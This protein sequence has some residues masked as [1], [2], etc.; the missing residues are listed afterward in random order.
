[1]HTARWRNYYRRTVETLRYEGLHRLLLRALPVFLSALG[2]L[3]LWRFFQKD[4]TQPL[5]K[6]RASVD[7]TIRQA[8]QSDIDQLAVL[9]E[10]QDRRYTRQGVR[11]TLIMQFL[12]GDKCFVANIGQEIVHYN[13]VLFQEEKL[14]SG[15]GVP[16]PMQDDEALCTDAFTAETWRGKNIHA[17]VNNEMLRFLRQAGYRKAYTMVATRNKSSEKALYRVGWT[18]CG[19][20]YYFIFRRTGRC[21]Q[22]WVAGTDVRKRGVRGGCGERAG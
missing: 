15:L 7:L 13:W 6:V 10:R 18:Y 22:L 16:I 20:L 19:S 3:G 9:I 4:L 1:M 5:R 11:K 14:D 12:R 8:T 21:L 2:D 17:A